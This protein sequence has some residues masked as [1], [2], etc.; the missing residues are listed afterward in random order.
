MAEGKVFRYSAPGDIP[1][2]LRLVVEVV[3]VDDHLLYRRLFG[4][5][6][7]KEVAISSEQ[8]E[9]LRAALCEEGWRIE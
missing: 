8:V 3:K 9:Q 7:I 6:V 4:G 5:E 2:E 1:E